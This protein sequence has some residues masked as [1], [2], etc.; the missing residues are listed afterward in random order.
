MKKLKELW[1]KYKLMR[2][3]LALVRH[4][5]RTDLIIEG[6]ELLKKMPNQSVINKMLAAFREGHPE[7]ADMMDE[8]YMPRKP[9]LEE[10]K[11]MPEGSFGCALFEHLDKNNIDFNVFPDNLPESDLDYVNQRMYLD[12]DLWHVL[13]GASTE[14]EDELSLQA[15]N[16]AQLGTPLGAMIIS[17][18]ILHLLNK[19]PLRAAHAMGK[20]SDGY[21]TG[22]NAKFLLEVKLHEMFKMP[23]EHVRR[24]VKIYNPAHAPM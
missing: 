7:F 5:E 20:I 2:G 19:D 11:N 17:G 1:I 9:A 21:Q 4:P 16:V 8:R 3:Y 24:E 14:V 18:G 10:L 22:K 12:H 13:M 23:L 6:I 15:F